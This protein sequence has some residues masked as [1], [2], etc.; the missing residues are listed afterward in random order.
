VRRYACDA[1]RW[2]DRRHR[3][4]PSGETVTIGT[5]NATHLDAPYHYNSTIQGARSQTIE[6]LPLERLFAPGVVVEA[7]ARAVA[8]R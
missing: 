2:P 8:M 5:H 3:A 4:Q 7:S 6:Q 1:H